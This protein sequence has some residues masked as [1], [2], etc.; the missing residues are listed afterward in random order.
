MAGAQKLLRICCT[1]TAVGRL[2]RLLYRALK[3]NVPD[4]VVVVVVGEVV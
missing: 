4:A 2:E 3:W 1:P